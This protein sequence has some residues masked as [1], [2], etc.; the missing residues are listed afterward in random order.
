MFCKI[1]L[2]KWKSHSS[3]W[4]FMSFQCP[5]VVPEGTTE[6]AQHY[7]SCCVLQVT[8]RNGFDVHQTREFCF[9]QSESLSGAFLLILRLSTGHFASRPRL[10]KCCSSAIYTHGLRFLVNTL[11]KG[12]LQWLLTLVRKIPGCSKIHF[13]KNYGGHCALG[14]LQL[15]RNVSVAFPRSVPPDGLVFAMIC[16]F[17]C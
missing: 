8:L 10:A 6:A 14:N 4:I 9:P 2:L 1:C 16:I 13:I 12:L 7:F 15:N 3:E 5:P 11:T 17:S